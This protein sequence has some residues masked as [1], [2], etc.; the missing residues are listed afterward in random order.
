MIR[1]GSRGPSRGIRH[2][3]L[4]TRGRCLALALAAAV[5]GSAEA[6]SALRPR[7]LGGHIALGYHS[8]I[9]G[10]S[11]SER[12]A[13]DAGDPEAFFVVE[14]LDDARA[15]V[16]LWGRW[17]L[18]SFHKRLRLELGL[19]RSEWLRTG[20]LG[21]SRY[22]I[23]LRQRLPQDWAVDFRVRHSPQIYMRHRADKDAPPGAPLFRP[24]AIAETEIRAALSRAL[25]SARAS[26][27]YQRGSEDRTR[28]F[29]ER[30]ETI[31]DGMA[32]LRWEATS[33]VQVGSEYLFARGRSRNE[34]DL[35]SDRSYRE[36]GVSLAV[37]YEDAGR[38]GIAVSGRLK[39]RRYTTADSDDESRYRRRDRIYGVGIR[40][41]FPL[42]SVRP[43]A[44][45]ERS[46]RLVTLPAG[47]DASDEDGEYA[48]TWIRSGL[49]WE[50]R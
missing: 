2:C 31:D 34:P 25:G 40:V 29:D 48:S 15:E 37:A 11:T 17:D 27:A 38:L 8:N 12:S 4:V 7:A 9:L 10:S 42:A 36:H 18:P 28:W 47:A 1:L 35:G 24:E 39:W 22:E 45:V 5:A 19:Q 50:I 14:R 23:D 44:A 30:D 49:E 26:V 41:S 33:S 16:G 6:S 32:G 20:I 3:E 43:F 46:G 21:Q 13:F